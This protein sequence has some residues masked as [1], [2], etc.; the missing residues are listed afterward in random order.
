MRAARG[1]LAADYRTVRRVRQ[2][3]KKVIVAA[4]RM[5]HIVLFSVIVVLVA[6][7]LPFTSL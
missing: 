4:R 5:M 3:V 2:K 6:V 7:D 1:C